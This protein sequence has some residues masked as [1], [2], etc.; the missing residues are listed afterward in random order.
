MITALTPIIG[1][2]KI[3]SPSGRVYIGQS[4]NIKKRW[5]KYKSG[6]DHT[7]QHALR[8]SFKKYD[9]KNH[10]FEIIKQL[11]DNCDQSEL[12]LYEIF[13]IS[14]YRGHGF[15]MLNLRSGGMGG[16]LSEES[17]KRISLAQKG[18]RKA[19][20]GSFVK[21]QVRYPRT[22]EMIEKIR[23]KNTGKKCSDETKKKLSEINKGENHPK[24][25]KSISQL[26]KDKIS[27]K[28]LGKKH[29]EKTLDKMRRVQKESFAKGIRT[30]RKGESHPSYKLTNAQIL[31]IREKHV[32]RLYSTRMLAKEY[33]VSS[34]LIVLILQNKR[35]HAS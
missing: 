20:S 8:N 6:A 5:Y 25:G 16:K 24:F 10:T 2:Y 17:K 7:N 28:H 33:Q 34:S 1:I 4:W 14:H 32:P 31:E 13:Y 15:K 29:S 9:A 12:D 21:G 19:N 22:A 18:K 35:R 26:T 30:V 27:Q 3:T 23:E 11:P